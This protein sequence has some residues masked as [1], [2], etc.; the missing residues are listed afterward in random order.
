[1][2]VEL[3]EQSLIKFVFFWYD[4]IYHEDHSDDFLI[5]EYFDIRMFK[6]YLFLGSKRN[7]S[8]AEF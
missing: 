8:E 2:C 4:F 6:L 3:N 5:N 1:M 7:L